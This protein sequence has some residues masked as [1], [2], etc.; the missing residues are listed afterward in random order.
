M[1]NTYPRELLAQ[2]RRKDR[3]YNIDL[4]GPEGQAPVSSDYMT[5]GQ[6]K[7]QMEQSWASPAPQSLANPS[8]DR[9]LEDVKANWAQSRQ[10]ST[11][12]DQQFKQAMKT[13]T[14]V[15]HTGFLQ[16]SAGRTY[17]TVSKGGV[18]EPSVIEPR[19]GRLQNPLQ[20]SAPII[21]GKRGPA[22]DAEMA[23]AYPGPPY[24][25]PEPVSGGI[26]ASAWGGTMA[27]ITLQPG[28]DLFAKTIPY[29]GIEM[30][31]ALKT[32]R[33]E[34][35]RQFANMLRDQSFTSIENYQR[36]GITLPTAGADIQ[37]HIRDRMLENM[38]A[39]LRQEY[40]QKIDEQKG[41]QKVE[42]E[43]M[44]KI[45][46]TRAEEAE[47]RRQAQ[48]T[49]GTRHP[50]EVVRGTSGKLEYQ[51]I[52]GND[53]FQRLTRAAQSKVETDL[54]FLQTATA[55]QLERIN[56]SPTQ[57]TEQIKK[58]EEFYGL[59]EYAQPVAPAAGIPAPTPVTPGRG[60]ITSPATG[61]TVQTGT[62][63]PIPSVTGQQG[64][65]TP[66]SAKLTVL[67]DDPTLTPEQR[68]A[69]QAKLSQLQGK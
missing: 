33:A 25:A 69:V 21:R 38:P 30:D 47:M 65:A 31:P 13:G 62:P 27:P 60:F 11:A 26:D 50:M 32:R 56:V 67:L 4:I 45:R 51:E 55:G 7:K 48:E 3:R 20:P 12:R 41:I 35:D 49:L 6:S 61:Q 16:P 66:A 8:I 54:A 40:Q 53:K 28:E 46:G 36:A 68:Q 34:F 1:P 39:N 9:M 37:A 59:G 29:T 44:L 5:Y 2:Q 52:H 63:A 58:I 19:R 43:A 23:A 10:E 18:T 64:K 22:T 15:P 57:A 24:G 14:L 42:S 17:S